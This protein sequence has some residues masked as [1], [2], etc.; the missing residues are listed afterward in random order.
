MCLGQDF[1]INPE[2]LLLARGATLNP[3]HID[4]IQQL[5]EATPSFNYVL[6]YKDDAPVSDA[7]SS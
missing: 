6:I 7:V 2:I 4:R 1:A 3:S 5:S